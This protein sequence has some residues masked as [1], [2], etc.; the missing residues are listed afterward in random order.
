MREDTGLK[1]LVTQKIEFTD[2]PMDDF[3]F[4]ISNGVLMLKGEY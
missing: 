3:E 2:F 4:Y 1:P